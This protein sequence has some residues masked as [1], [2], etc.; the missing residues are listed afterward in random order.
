MPRLDLCWGA[1]A[2]FAVE[3]F[4]V[5]PPHP[6]QRRE[7]DLLDCSPG[8][9]AADQLG[10]VE[11]IDG[12]SESIVGTSPRAVWRRLLL[13]QSTHAMVTH[14]TSSMVFRGPFRNGPSS[15]I[16]SVLNSPIVDSA[17]A[18]HRERSVPL[19]T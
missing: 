1:V 5:P 17:S 11:T 4:V 8:A 7:L 15:R 18:D 6:F 19:G 14:S 13:D 16:A 10:L 3:A 9:A 2:E 12:P